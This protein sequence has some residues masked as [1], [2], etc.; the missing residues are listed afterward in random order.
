M[1]V[2]AILK[3]NIPQNERA[4]RVGNVGNVRWKV[5]TL[6][7][8]TCMGIRYSPLDERWGAREIE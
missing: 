3:H 8:C 1:T 6:L 5:M 2:M 4:R 7:E